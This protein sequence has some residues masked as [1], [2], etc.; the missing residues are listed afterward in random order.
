MKFSNK[1]QECFDDIIHFVLNSSEQC[2]VFSGVAGSGKT[3]IIKEVD[4]YLNIMGYTSAN[5]ALTGKAVSVMRHKGITHTSTI[6][7]LLYNAIWDKKTKEFIGYE[8]RKKE[9][10]QKIADYI[11]ID[12]SSM[13]NSDLFQDLIDTE[14]PLLF[15][16]D[17]EQLPAIDHKYPNFNLME[18]FDIHLSEIHRQAENNP[19]I[20]L[21][22]H[23]RETGNFN[24]NLSDQKTIQFINK[25][26]V[27]KDLLIS[28]AQDIIICG[29]NKKKD[30]LNRL[31][32]ASYGFHE[33][34]AEKGETIICLR[35]D[36][37]TE[38]FMFNGEIYEVLNRTPYPHKPAG[39]YELLNKITTGIINANILNSDWHGTKPDRNNGFN[40]F[41]FGYCISTWKAQG[42]EFNK[43]LF[44]DQDVS[45]FSDQRKF[46]YTSVTRAIKNLIIAT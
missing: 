32:R 26:K 33:D 1:Q 21:S 12:E 7:S 22:R 6:H 28:T 41:D 44:I 10:I 4:R 3:C 17:S 18:N 24:K 31:A 45:Y 19:I 43:V 40:Y 20:K 39:N 29:T 23:I 16:G 14:L 27:N 15:V 13:V 30:S 8:K 35:N 5:I 34:Y 38:H 11:I 9:D 2:Y 42:S 46:R 36:V 25:N 37:C